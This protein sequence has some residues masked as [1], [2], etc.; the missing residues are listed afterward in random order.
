VPSEKAR[1]IGAE[2]E[3]C[4]HKIG[5]VTSVQVRNFLVYLRKFNGWLDALEFQITRE[6]LKEMAE[7]LE[8]V[9]Q[10]VPKE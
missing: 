6:S 1:I 3:P 9:K 8:A 5:D 10:K 7:L 4:R 2:G